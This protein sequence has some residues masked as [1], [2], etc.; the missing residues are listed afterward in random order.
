MS[1]EQIDIALAAFIETCDYDHAIEYIKEQY[2][3]YEE[4]YYQ[5]ETIK[6]CCEFYS[7]I[8]NALD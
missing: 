2:P 1:K 7:R 8:I 4:G 6:K 3:R 5:T